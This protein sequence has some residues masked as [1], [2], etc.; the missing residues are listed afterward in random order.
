MT[1]ILRSDCAVSEALFLIHVMD[2][3]GWPFAV[4][5][6][7]TSKPATTVWFLGSVTVSGFRKAEKS[8]AK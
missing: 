7:V 8:D 3:M 6:K 2:G 4:Q 1:F 5:L